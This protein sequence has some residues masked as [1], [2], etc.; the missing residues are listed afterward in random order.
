MLNPREVVTIFWEAGFDMRLDISDA[1]VYEWDALFAAAILESH[2]DSLLY[3]VKHLHPDDTWPSLSAMIDS[4]KRLVLFSDL[5]TMKTLRGVNR[6]KYSIAQTSY[7][8]LDK[9]HLS[10]ACEYVRD[11]T[12]DSEIL[13]INQFTMLST[14]GINSASAE[15]LGNFLNINFFK[16]VNREPYFSERVLAC[17]HKLKK[18]PTFIA[19]DFW[20]SSDVFIVVDKLNNHSLFDYV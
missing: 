10:Q 3:S 8:A 9:Q 16:N 19:V 7:N 5:Y 18:F 13:V 11:V 2:I 1:L 15:W 20:E 6:M 14:L 4:G 17:A 12:L